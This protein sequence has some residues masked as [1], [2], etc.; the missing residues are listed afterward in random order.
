MRRDSLEARPT[1]V[2][3]K[4]PGLL[5]TPAQRR[6]AY[7]DPDGRA[8]VGRQPEHRRRR[9]SLDDADVDQRAAVVFRPEDRVAQ[10]FV[11][12]LTKLLSLLAVG[13]DTIHRELR[14][15]H[16]RI[17]ARVGKLIGRSQEGVERAVASRMHARDQRE[18]ALG[19]RAGD[20][21]RGLAES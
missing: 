16:V 21:R 13:R 20:E 1:Y 5:P 18:R 14:P 7:P 11:G 10:V 2:T 19:R 17:D 3:P 15:N 4:P 12:L 9:A 6:T 8:A